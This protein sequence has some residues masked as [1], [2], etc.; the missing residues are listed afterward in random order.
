MIKNLT[1]WLLCCLMTACATTAKSPSE[2]AGD[3]TT[4]IAFKHIS[5]IE[6]QSDQITFNKAL[7]EYEHTHNAGVLTDTLLNPMKRSPKIAKYM[8][9]H[10]LVTLAGQ[11]GHYYANEIALRTIIQSGQVEP[12]LK[13]YWNNVL[14][15]PVPYWFKVE[16]ATGASV[17]AANELDNG[18]AQNML[19]IYSLH[20]CPTFDLADSRKIHGDASKTDLLSMALN[21]CKDYPTDAVKWAG[22]YLANK[23]VSS[24]EKTNLIEKMGDYYFD[25]KDYPHAA[26][27]YKLLLELQTSKFDE[28]KLSSLRDTIRFKMLLGAGISIDWYL[29]KFTADFLG[30]EIYKHQKAYRRL[31]LIKNAGISNFVDYGI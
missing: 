23:K 16:F 2:Q 31:E 29:N 19:A 14:Y 22:Q 24:I 10:Q 4:K 9:D 13:T 18:Y 26:G 7:L 15:Q 27:Y 12:Y 3:T 28:E 30:N 8:I 11:N 25:L 6:Q 21:K 5:Y 17:W 20:A 1:I